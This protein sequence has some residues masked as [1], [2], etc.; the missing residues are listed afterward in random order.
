LLRAKLHSTWTTF[1]NWN[2][3]VKGETE[4]IKTEKCVHPGDSDET[5]G[6]RQQTTY[7][8]FDVYCTGP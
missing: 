7:N 6:K 3:L 4:P 8:V 1:Q 2:A 5:Q